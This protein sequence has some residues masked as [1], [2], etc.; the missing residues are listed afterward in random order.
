MYNSASTA[1]IAATVAEAT[2]QNA[3]GSKAMN[4]R[5]QELEIYHQAVNAFCSTASAVKATAQMHSVP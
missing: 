5:G 3:T 2:T 1:S 4:R